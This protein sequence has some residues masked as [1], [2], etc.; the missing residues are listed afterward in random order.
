M[1]TQHERDA[2]REFGYYATTFTTEAALAQAGRVLEIADIEEAEAEYDVELDELCSPFA[3]D[4]E[5][6]RAQ[7]LS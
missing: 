1:L 3:T 2:L 4:V 6:L 5:R 7:V